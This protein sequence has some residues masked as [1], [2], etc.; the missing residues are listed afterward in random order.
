M[1]LKE[2]KKMAKRCLQMWDSSLAKE[3]ANK[4]QYRKNGS[5]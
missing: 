3:V 1:E 4:K 2:F 5:Y